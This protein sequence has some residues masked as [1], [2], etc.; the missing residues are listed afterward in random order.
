MEIYVV[1]PGDTIEEIANMYGVTAEKLIRD[2]EL[3]NP[4]RLL[5]GQAI[6]I[7]YPSETYTVM[8]GDTLETIA[9]SNNITVNELLR[10][11]PFIADR[12]DIYP[13]EELAISFN[14]SGS[15][16][17]YGYTN[18]FI[19]RQTLR[20]TLP[21]L[22]YLSIFNYQVTDTGE[23]LGNDDDID[24]IQSAIQYGVIPLMH[25]ATLTIQGEVDLE[26]TY[27]LFFDEDLQDKLFENVLIILRD[28]GYYG[29]VIS[30]QYITSENQHLFFIYVQRFS[31]RI[32]QE[33]YITLVAVDPKV[34]TFDSEVTIEN[35]DYSRFPDSIYRI[36]LLEYTWG[37]ITSPP[38]PIFSI[39]SLNA[40]L[41][42]ILPQIDPSKISIGIP[43]LGYMWELPY[44][45]GL[46]SS[47]S[48]TRNN[49]INLAVEVNAIIQFDPVSQTPYFT[50]AD[51]TSENLQYI[52]WF[53][54]SITIDSLMKVLSQR[55]VFS[56]GVWNIMSYFAVLWLVINSQ[57][58]I[59]KLLPEN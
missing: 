37:I 28:K 12:R 7:V 33:G 59:A 4:Y 23:A 44:V 13:G 16:S 30:A 45:E 48:L 10:N 14:R 27:R 34:N 56:V 24:I 57:Y 51:S 8:Y 40:L 42:Y 17:T 32:G 9:A 5:T 6:V 3:P 35:I 41:D 26:L 29:V 39:N 36:L 52:V 1:Q 54:S 18:T 50:F 11:N 2:N 15:F 38:A 47:S 21:F 55:G 53:I 58:K 46:S 43:V 20:K 31:E 22:T 19:N 25:L 49:V